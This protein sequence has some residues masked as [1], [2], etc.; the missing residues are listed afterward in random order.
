[1]ATA[2]SLQLAERLLIQPEKLAQ[3]LILFLLATVPLVFGSVHPIVQ[4]VY[5]VLILVGLGGWLLFVMPELSWKDFSTFWLIVPLVLL[6][7]I[8]LQSLP[9]PLHMVELLSPARAERINM[10][11]SLAQTELTTAAISDNG[12]AGLRETI[13]GVSLLLYYLVLTT[14]LK[15]DKKIVFTLLYVIAGVGLFEGVYGLLQVMNPH[16]GILWLSVTSKGAAHGTIIYKNQYASLL[17]MCWPL[18]LAGGILFLDSLKDRV[19]R[20]SR[21]SRVQEFFQSLSLV[22]IQA[23]LFFF[24]A[25]VMILAVLFS[26]SRG[27]ILV[28]LLLIVLLN[29]FLPSARR[30]KLVL[31]VLLL[32][33]MGGYGSLLGL[34]EVFRRFDTID[35]SGLGRFHVYIS[36]LPMLLDHWF[37]GIGLGSYKLLSGVY[38][39]GFPEN[40]LFDRAHNDYLE[41]ALEVGL[42]MALLF[43]VW[44]LS[45]ILVTGNTL[46]QKSRILHAECRTSMIVGCA[47]FCSLLGFLIHGLVDFGWRLPANALYAVTMVALITHAI[48]DHRLPAED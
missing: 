29:L 17:N 42:P 5:T 13:F 36:S 19:T 27:G 31:T 8:V 2:I 16:I 7:F 4:A 40:L 44:L 37:T 32:L 9:L 1:M 11:N 30:I 22:N 10:V 34:E 14:L 6:V 21:K 18:A 24:A 45:G 41:L 23:P 48:Q 35:E 33:F 46:V 39:K 3:G 28:M 47:A 26:L 15:R 20:G 43:F 38:L 12:I 25:G